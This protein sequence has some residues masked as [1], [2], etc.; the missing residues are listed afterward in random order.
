MCSTAAAINPE[1]TVATSTSCIAC[2][3]GCLV[4]AFISSVLSPPALS[5]LLFVL[6][7]N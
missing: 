5:M 4:I 6:M 7:E 1:E 2:F 3:N